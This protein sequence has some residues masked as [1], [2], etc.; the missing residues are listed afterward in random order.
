[1]RMLLKLTYVDMKLYLRNW[2][3][4]FFSLVFP[5]LML[6][7]FGSMYGN[8]PSP[9]FDGYGSMDVTIPGYI[10]SL[11]IGTTGLLSL[12]IELVARRQQGILRRFSVTPLPAITV[13]T[14]QFMVNLSMSVLGAGMLLLGG[15]CVYNVVM[16][17]DVLQTILGFMLGTLSTF[18]LGFVI[19]SLVKTINAAR[20][21]TMAIFYPMMFLSGGTLPAVFFPKTVQ[22]IANWM[23]MTYVVRLMQNLWFGKGWDLTSV[24]VL[25]AIL[26]VCTVISARFFRWN[27]V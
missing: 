26:V 4:T 25:A 13:L 5:I 6:F 16:P 15:V 17:V 24:I 20:A 2:I 23:P 21:I 22:N 11:I 8:K 10:A 1:M 14:S 7:L 19:A 18:A 27:P 3:A 9:I 12:P